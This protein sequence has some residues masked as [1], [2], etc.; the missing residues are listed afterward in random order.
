MHDDARRCAFVQQRC[1]QS[2]HMLSGYLIRCTGK[3]IACH[4]LVK[5]WIYYRF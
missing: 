3:E 5:L 4:Y 2:V 1:A